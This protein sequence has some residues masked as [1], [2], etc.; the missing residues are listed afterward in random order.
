MVQNSEIDE[1]QEL[2]LLRFLDGE[3]GLFEKLRANQLLKT[4]AEARSFIEEMRSLGD[5]T[6]RSMSVKAVESQHGKIDLWDKISTRIEQ[7]ER[8]EFFLGKR[9]TIQ[10]NQQS[11]WSSYFPSQLAWGFS[12]VAASVI[13][14]LVL[15]QGEYINI[16]QKEFAAANTVSQ[17]GNSKIESV[18]MQ[19]RSRVA[20]SVSS[21]ST[22]PTR[23]QSEVPVIL[24]NNSI[25]AL[26]IDWLRSDGR[27]ELLQDDHLQEMPPLFWIDPKPTSASR[28]HRA[29]DRRYLRLKDRL[30]S[31]S[32]SNE[33][34]VRE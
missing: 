30:S 29:R 21:V 17:R 34:L 26:E 31:M 27:V 7:E 5:E 20:P 24:N 33:L 9:E 2:M 12:G 3:C 14:A 13:F 8:A 23:R 1:K 18:A 15:V 6:R 22:Y 32:E 16:G 4:S 11:S 10:S 19:P 25:G 28:L